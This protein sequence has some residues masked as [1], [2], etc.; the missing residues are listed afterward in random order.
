MPEL[1]EVEDAACR[2]R[3]AMVGR[4]IVS[5]TTHHAAQRRAL[6]TATARAL[7]G[8]RVESVVRRAKLQ[9]VTLSNGYVVEVHF[10][11][12]GDW[13]IGRES[14][15][16]PAHERVRWVLDDGTRVS[17]VDS[18]ALCVVKA[19][20]PGTF[21]LPDLGPEPLDDEWTASALAASLAR[22]SGPI[23]PVLLDQKVVSGLGNIYAAESLWEARIDPRTPARQL[24]RARVSRLRDAI[25]TV[26][27]RAMPGRYYATKASPETDPSAWRV[28]DRE[29][30]PCVRCGRPIKRIVQ[31][32]RSTFW[33]SG[34]QS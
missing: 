21:E 22:R 18:R 3:N 5:V 17:L 7:A 27:G 23:K 33:C 26:L 34:C 30:E 31:A 13:D 6:P 2:L 8:A 16:E 14:D 11:M 1:P 19:H 9:L 20:K 28:Y 12:N 10:R 32:A 24:S 15:P 29:G 4:T 25:R